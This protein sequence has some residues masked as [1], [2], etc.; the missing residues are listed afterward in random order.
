ML[1]YYCVVSNISTN[2]AKAGGNLHYL[3]QCQS[4]NDELAQLLANVNNQISNGFVLI[5]DHQTHGR[6]QR[7]NRWESED[8]KNLTFSLAWFPTFLE[9]RHSFWLSAAVSLAVVST[10][11][12]LFPDCQVKWPNDIYCK[13]KK[14]GGILIENTVVGMNM[15]R[16]IIG[17]GLNVNQQNLPKNATSLCL[18]LNSEVNRVEILNQIRTQIPIWINRLEQ[19][20]WQKIRSS[21]YQNLY[22]MARPHDYVLPDGTPFRAVLKG[23]SDSGHLI[24]ITPTGEQRFAFKEVSFRL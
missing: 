9:A 14:L 6:G 19:D 20:G 1:Q 3:P 13:G 15:D 24:L 23:I 5:T 4:T 17:I 12:P 8:G 2:L 7:G 10:L 22:L 16:S 21:Y 11:K 18:E